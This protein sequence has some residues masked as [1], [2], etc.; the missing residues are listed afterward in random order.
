M[1]TVLSLPSA[2]SRR[3]LTMGLAV[4]VTTVTIA[5]GAPFRQDASAAVTAVPLGTSAGFAVLAG[6]GIT[7]TGPTTIT[8]DIGSY[9]TL[10]QTG[11]ASLTLTGVNHRGDRVT[12]RAKTDLTTGYTVAAGESPSTP[13]AADLGGRTLTAGVYSSASSIGL[14]GVLT[15]DAAGDPNAIFVFQAGSALTTA[16]GSQV[17]LINGASVCNVY[18]QVGSSA[19]LG[20]G[21][22]FRGNL[23]ALTSVTLTTGA[24]TIGRVLARNGAVTLDTNTITK[25]A[26]AATTPSPTVSATTTATPTVSA[27]RTATP[28]ATSGTTSGVP[29]PTTTSHQVTLVPTGSVHTG[30]GS[31]AGG[32]RHGGI[33]IAAAIAFAGAALVLLSVLR[34]RRQ[35]A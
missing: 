21:S 7:N 4:L 17:A 10:S 23:L 27:T 20:T 31:T 5:V 19:T 33:I 14:T 29:A 30:D 22:S 13:I 6:A 24:S 8:G 25:P 1:N 28:T 34:R 35:S 11:T 3:A 12:Q 18:W 16:S 26:C 2:T 32:E 9:P 15:L